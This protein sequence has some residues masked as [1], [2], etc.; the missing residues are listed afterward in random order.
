M[1]EKL[2]I[3]LAK[4]SILSIMPGAAIWAITDRLMTR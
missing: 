2:P 1:L 4:G 3:L